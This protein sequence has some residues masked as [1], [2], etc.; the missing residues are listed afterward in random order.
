MLKWCAYCQHFIGE[1][2]PYEDFAIT[3]GLC[4]DCASRH[5]DVFKESVVARGRSLQELFT[6]L[7][8]AGL[9]S[10]FETAQQ[11]VKK[12]MA[13]NC[14]PVDILIG[15]IAPMLYEI[16]DR[17][18]RGSI[19]VD[20]EHRFTACCKQVVGLVENKLN[21]SKVAADA[22]LHDAS[23]ALIN[24]PGNEHTLAIR[25]LALWLE[26][27]GKR[28]RTL[29]YHT[30][31]EELS[32]ILVKERPNSLLISMALLEQASGVAEL[33]ALVSSLP[34]SVRPKVIVGG[35]AIKVGL[36]SAIPGA[37]LVADISSLKLE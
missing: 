5:D 27:R 15:L 33:V 4:D 37:K 19:T 32:E 6:S 24:A 26:S 35:Y 25:T 8:D 18:E 34:A 21:L 3:H 7:F 28:T 1:V 29:D 22:S 36:I 20:D 12:A 11:T 31:P 16:G 2:R 14:R 9:K 10:D 30:S 17:W 13:A 23:F